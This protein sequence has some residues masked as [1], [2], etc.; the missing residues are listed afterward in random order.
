MNLVEAVTHV[1]EKSKK[2]RFTQTYELIINLK[3][4][5]DLKKAENRV[6]DYFELPHGR[7]KK[8]KICAIVAQELEKPASKVFDYV[9]LRDKLPEIAGNKRLAKKIAKSYYIFVAQALVMPDIG[10]YLGKYLGPRDKMPNP[11]YGMIVPNNALEEQL[12]STYDRLQKLVRVSIKNHLTFGVPIGTEEMDPKLVAE[13]AREF[14]NWLFNRIP[15]GRQSI[16]SV[17]LKL[18]MSNSIRII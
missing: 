14:L 7:G 11:K 6:V 8:V 17:Y 12:R 13:N 2:R 15:G 18:T 3:K 1:K 5:Y 4:D 9:I 16:G 10:K